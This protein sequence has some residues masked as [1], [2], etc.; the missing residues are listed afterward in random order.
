MAF[1]YVNAAEACRNQL[2]RLHGLEGLVDLAYEEVARLAQHALRARVDETLDFER[3]LKT[4]VALGKHVERLEA[5]EI[6]HGRVRAEAQD[7]DL[8]VACRIECLE[9]RRRRAE[10]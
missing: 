6:G 10:E 7:D 9:E 3:L 2:V 8:R 1:L 4:L 5:R